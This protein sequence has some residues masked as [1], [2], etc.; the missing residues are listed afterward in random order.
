M[1]KH[2]IWNRFRAL[3]L[4]G[5]AFCAAACN[6]L[7]EP[8][9]TIQGTYAYRSTSQVSPAHNRE[10]MITIVDSDPRSARFDGSYQY[11]TAD[12]ERVAGQLIGAFVHSER[13]WFRFLDERQFFHEGDFILGVS[14]GRVFFLGLN[15]VPTS[16]TF[17]LLRR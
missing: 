16:T 12:G 17:S 14:A 3:I 1:H 13:I 7:T 11:V 2:K 8:L 6:D 10:G 5:L 15:Y 4:P 9:P